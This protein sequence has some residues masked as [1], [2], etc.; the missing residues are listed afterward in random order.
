MT[1]DAG[2]WLAATPVDRARAA[3]DALGTE[4]LASWCADVLSGQCDLLGAGGLSAPASPDRRWLGVDAVGPWGDP[5]TW[6]DRGFGYWP[7]VWAARTLLHQW[8]PLAASAVRQGLSDPAWRV[9]E[10]CAKVAARHEAS[11]AADDCA[12]LATRDST[13]RV[14]MAALRVLAVVGE[15]EHVPA[16]LAALD[17]EDRAVVD[18]AER[19]LTTI[20]QRLDRRFPG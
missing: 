4:E 18:R 20:E 7:R 6:P 16:V 8:H 13:P 14:R 2:A 17:D 1:G 10:M 19:A 15:S 5:A 9:R 3:A 12:R 11:I